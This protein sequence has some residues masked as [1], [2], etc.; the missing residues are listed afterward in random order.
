MLMLIMLSLRLS[1]PVMPMILLMSRHAALLRAIAAIYAAAMI[2]D[3]RRHFR[4]HR[5]AARR[6]FIF[7]LTPRC[8]FFFAFVYARCHAADCYC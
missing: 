8:C 5:F 4:R 7:S 2:T 1:A 3:F 6:H